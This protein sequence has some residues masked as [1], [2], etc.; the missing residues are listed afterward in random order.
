MH[1]S[2]KYPADPWLLYA[3]AFSEPLEVKP[4]GMTGTLIDITPHDIRI[5]AS[6]KSKVI[7]IHVKA[8]VKQA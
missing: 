5:K 3:D 6:V 7:I 1:I 4:T 8:G 2:V